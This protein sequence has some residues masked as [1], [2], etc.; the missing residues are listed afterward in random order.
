V[1][2]GGIATELPPYGGLNNDFEIAGFTHSEYWNAHMAGCGGQL[3]APSAL[4]CLPV[5]F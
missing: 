3:F 1:I 5:G 2:A 4:A